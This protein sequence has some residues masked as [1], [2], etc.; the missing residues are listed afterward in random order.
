[1]LLLSL[2]ALMPKPPSILVTASLAN[3]GQYPSLTHLLTIC[4]QAAKRGREQKMQELEDKAATGG[5]RGVSVA[6]NE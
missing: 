1:M 2:L 6:W 3:E 4:M 5:V